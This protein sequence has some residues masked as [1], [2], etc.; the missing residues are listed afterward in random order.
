M[1]LEFM[2]QIMD[3]ADIVTIYSWP[4][5]VVCGILGH[6]KRIQGSLY[7]EKLFANGVGLPQNQKSHDTC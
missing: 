1:P 7:R 6:Y 4:Q 3:N 5:I 2:K